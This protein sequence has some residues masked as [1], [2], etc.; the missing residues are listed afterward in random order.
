MAA[1]NRWRSVGQPIAMGHGHWCPWP[2]PLCKIG[3]K[4]HHL[5]RVKRWQ[6]TGLREISEKG[7]W[8][9]WG[10]KMGSLRSVGRGKLGYGLHDISGEDYISCCIQMLWDEQNMLSSWYIIVTVNAFWH[11]KF[12]VYKYLQCPNIF[13]ESANSLSLALFCLISI[14]ILQQ[15]LVT[16]EMGVS[17]VKFVHFC[18]EGRHPVGHGQHVEGHGWTR[19]SDAVRVW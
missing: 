12:Q 7:N 18:S 15:N 16:I 13:I 9:Q 8:D 4:S 11:G 2:R 6:L 10:G 5:K 3:E 19:P 1:G 17:M 14:V